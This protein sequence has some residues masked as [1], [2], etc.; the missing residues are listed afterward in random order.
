MRNES[1]QPVRQTSEDKKET[2]ALT[3]LRGGFW[4]DSV[5][6]G[7]HGARCVADHLVRRGDRQMR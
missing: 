3:R 4:G 5:P 6:N 2:A 7:E 1:S